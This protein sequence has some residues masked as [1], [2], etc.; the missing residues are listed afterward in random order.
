MKKLIEKIE[1][2]LKENPNLDNPAP[3]SY[4]HGYRSALINI[5]AIIKAENGN[6]MTAK[7]F[8]KSKSIS[9]DEFIEIDGNGYTVMLIDLLEE[10]AM[11]TMNLKTDDSYE[12]IP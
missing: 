12:K 8:L 5:I 7:E 6:I 4:Y 1:A 2:P 3:H 9:T 10:Y 11:F